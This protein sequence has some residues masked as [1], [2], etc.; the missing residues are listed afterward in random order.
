MSSKQDYVS[1]REFLADWYHIELV[2]LPNDVKG[3][4]VAE[5]N[6]ITWDMA[7]PKGRKQ[8]ASQIDMENDPALGDAR[9]FLSSMAEKRGE[10]VRAIFQWE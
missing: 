2:D 4:V 10:L 9:D 3:R 7:S 8:I 1:L 5:F 6:L